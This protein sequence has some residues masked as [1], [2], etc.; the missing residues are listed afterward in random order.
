MIQLIYAVSAMNQ[1]VALGQGNIC[2]RAEGIRRPNY[3]SN[4]SYQAFAHQNDLALGNQ[5]N[6]RYL[7]RTADPAI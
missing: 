2:T 3:G 4:E 7:N 5:L 6:S 1:G